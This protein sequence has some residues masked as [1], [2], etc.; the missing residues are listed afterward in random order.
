MRSKAEVI[1]RHQQTLYFIRDTLLELTQYTLEIAAN[2]QHTINSKRLRELRAVAQILNTTTSISGKL[3]E[4]EKDA[5]G[6]MTSREAALI[7]MRKS[8]AE[9]E[10]VRANINLTM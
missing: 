1:A 6:I 2:E 5:H 8:S 4:L 9:K 3:F 7:N 10:G